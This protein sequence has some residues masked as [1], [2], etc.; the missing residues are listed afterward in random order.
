[1]ALTKRTPKC[2]A[3]PPGTRDQ[4]VWGYTCSGKLHHHLQGLSLLAIS[5]HEHPS[6]LVNVY[7][8]TGLYLSECHN[9]CKIVITTEEKLKRVDFRNEGLRKLFFVHTQS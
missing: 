5:V 2:G 1:M 8:G 4:L 6:L 7:C 3:L 9:I